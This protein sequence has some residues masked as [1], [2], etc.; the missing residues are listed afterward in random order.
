MLITLKRSND[1]HPELA[2]PYDW[3]WMF[4]FLGARAVTGVETV[5]TTTTSAVLPV[6]GIRDFR[7]TPDIAT[8]TLTVTLSRG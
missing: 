1:V 3:Q 6:K 4:G 2:P 8:H 5:T 7:V